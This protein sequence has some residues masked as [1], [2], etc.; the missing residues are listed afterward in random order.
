MGLT[1]TYKWVSSQT[2]H[3]KTLQAVT[4]Y[5]DPVHQIKNK[6]F[7]LALIKFGSFVSIIQNKRLSQ[8]FILLQILENE[9]LRNIFKELCEIDEFQILL[10]NF[11]TCYPSLSKS[12]IIKSKVNQLFNHKKSHNESSRK[13]RL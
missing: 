2:M 13:K 12:K 4:E 3:E 1:I 11:L 6:E 10:L 8:T 7:N 9:Q 5:N